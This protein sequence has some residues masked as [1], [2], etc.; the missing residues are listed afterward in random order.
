MPLR[1][2]LL[3]LREYPVPERAMHLL[4]SLEGMTQEK[5]L[6]V[7]SDQDPNPL[8]EELTPVL[9]KGFTYWIPEAGPETWR[10]LVS[11]QK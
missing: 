6:L 10:I 9:R 5:P 11:C 7:V 8:L 1:L 3:D 2:Y 4:L